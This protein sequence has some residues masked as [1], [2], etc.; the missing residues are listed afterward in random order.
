MASCKTVRQLRVCVLGYPVHD[1]YVFQLASAQDPLAQKIPCR[2]R[3]QWGGGAMN[4]SRAAMH[5]IGRN[6]V[7]AWLLVGDD[8]LG[9]SAKQ[10][11][12]S[13]HT[14]RVNEAT[15]R[16]IIVNGIAYTL[17]AQGGKQGHGE[18]AAALNAV[19]Q[20]LALTVVAPMP[21]N[22]RDFVHNL[23]TQSQGLTVLMLSLDQI[24]HDRQA[25]LELV[26]QASFVVLNELEATT[27]ARAADARGALEIL[28]L[29][30]PQTGTIVTT[31]ESGIFGAWRGQLV[32]TKPFRLSVSRKV[33]AGDCFTG[34]FAAALATG[35]KSFSEAVELGHAAAAAHVAGIKPMSLAVLEAW[36]IA[37]PRDN[38]RE[39]G[40]AAA[41]H[42]WPR[43]AWIS[44][45][46]TA[47]AL[48]LAWFLV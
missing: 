23:L 3:E 35:R 21:A 1:T 27:L 13:I 25:C 4:V 46:G 47:A 37:Q 29:E 45:T 41:A 26:R 9:T 38:H 8:L 34:T 10:Q 5:A 42:H 48:S 19:R 43:M 36:A 28:I 12:L 33:G 39:S 2:M 20:S 44:L 15:R 24:R 14:I 6:R 18:S 32:R 30:C 31:E 7:E 17:P 16:S 11:P 22:D 40:K